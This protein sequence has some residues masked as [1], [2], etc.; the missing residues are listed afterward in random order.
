[1]RER[2]TYGQT[3]Q[4]NCNSEKIESINKLSLKH[5]KQNFV[6]VLIHVF[7]SI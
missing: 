1:M 7:L 4:G 5:I 2:A 6:F 3:K